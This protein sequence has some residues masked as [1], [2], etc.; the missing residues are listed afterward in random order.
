[1]TDELQQARDN[2]NIALIDYRELIRQAL[3]T[4]A[5]ERVMPSTEPI[6]AAFT[7]LIEVATR[8][9]RT[10]LD[11][12]LGDIEWM[13]GSADFGPEGQVHEGWLKVRARLNEARA[14]LTQQPVPGAP[15]GGTDD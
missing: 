4:R 5:D 1:M 13:S 14:A 11:D 10:A 6:E 12:A 9:Y 7:T 2:Y 8:E 3:D 15:E